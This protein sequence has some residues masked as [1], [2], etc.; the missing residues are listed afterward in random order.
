MSD[1]EEL[2]FTDA[3]PPVPELERCGERHRARLC[4]PQPSDLSLVTPESLA[5]MVDRGGSDQS[6]DPHRYRTF[7]EAL[8]GEAKRRC[9]E[10]LVEDAERANKGF[11][12]TYE[13]VLKAARPDAPAP[14]LRG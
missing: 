9:A 11:A 12:E 5:R 1:R 10:K 4:E 7:D 6:V 3:P 14:L 2:R 8:R 13:A